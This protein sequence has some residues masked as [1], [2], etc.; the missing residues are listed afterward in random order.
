MSVRTRDYSKS[1]P[2]GTAVWHFGGS[3]L[4][5]GGSYPILIERGMVQDTIH[6][7]DNGPFFVDTVKIEGGTINGQQP[8]STVWSNYLADGY[9]G[10][11][12]YGHHPPADSPD[13]LAAATTG[14]RRTNPSRPSVDIPAEI[15]QLHEVPDLLRHEGDS[16]MKRAAGLHIKSEFGIQ[17]IVSDLVR[18][19][20]FKHVINSRVKEL[21]RLHRSGGLKRT[22][23][24]YKGSNTLQGDWTVQT[25]FGFYTVPSRWITSEEVRVHCRWFPSAT[26]FPFETND[27][28]LIQQASRAVK[29]LTIDMST[30]WQ[31]IPW[32]WLMDWCGSVGDYLAATRNVVGATLA[33]VSVMRHQR[34]E[35]HMGPSNVNGTARVSPCVV[36]K[37]TKNRTLSTVFPE[38]HMPFLTE[39]QLGIAAGL[40]I[41]KSSHA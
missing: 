39:G 5:I 37:E 35:F 1:V 11:D 4:S 26:F 29:G 12:Q 38:A 6:E 31:L 23:G 18:L 33:S 15:F 24:I 32:T 16:F 41:L 36:V 28:P 27:A 14:A 21:E 9:V 19:L 7:P 40:T 10:L 30:A 8:D 22:V 17:P 2:K 3:T 13:N 25:N 20:T 34:T